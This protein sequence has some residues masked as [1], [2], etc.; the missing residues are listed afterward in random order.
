MEKEK[1]KLVSELQSVFS[2]L[3]TCSSCHKRLAFMLLPLFVLAGY[4]QD[5]SFFLKKKKNQ[6]YFE[7]LF[8]VKGNHGARAR[9]CKALYL[10]K[11]H[12]T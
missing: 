8:L 1:S 10:S 6:Q 9:F 7:K 4:F 11:S 2:K 3:L 5:I 12:L